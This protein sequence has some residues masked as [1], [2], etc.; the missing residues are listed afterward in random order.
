[1]VGCDRGKLFGFRTLIGRRGKL[2]TFLESDMLDAASLWHS[3]MQFPCGVHTP[4]CPNPPIIDHPNVLHSPVLTFYGLMLCQ[5]SS[6]RSTHQGSPM[7]WCRLK[8]LCLKL[9]H[10][11][12]QS[13]HCIKLARK[14]GTRLEPCHQG[15]QATQLCT[16]VPTGSVGNK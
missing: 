12:Q 16:S 13:H 10:A 14:Q 1:M 6:K 9:Q 2:D 5:M 8:T 15:F 3:G 11:R 7:Y 4:P